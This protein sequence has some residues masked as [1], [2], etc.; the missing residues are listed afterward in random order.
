MGEVTLCLDIQ[1]N[2][3]FDRILYSSFPRS[4]RLIP[5]IKFQMVDRF[6]KYNGTVFLYSRYAGYFDMEIC[7]VSQPLPWNNRHSR[8]NPPLDQ[9]HNRPTV[10]RAAATE[11]K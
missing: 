8:M 3:M 6:G 2:D 11:N 7:S 5:M 4:P 1:L 9:F 10:E